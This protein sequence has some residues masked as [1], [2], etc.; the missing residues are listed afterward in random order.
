M[1]IG[2]VGLGA[3]RAR[4]VGVRS[5][6]GLVVAQQFHRLA[7]STE[8]EHTFATRYPPVGEP[9]YVL[10]VIDVRCGR[11]IRCAKF[12][13]LGRLVVLLGGADDQGAP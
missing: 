13:A 12:G 11:G 10:S 6:R 9:P 1:A 5:S 3:F 2:L 4:P 8:Y 7:W